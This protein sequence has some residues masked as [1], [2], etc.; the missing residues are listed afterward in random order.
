M[1]ARRRSRSFALALGRVDAAESALV[2]NPHTDGQHQRDP[3]AQQRALLG[4][5]AYSCP[6]GSPA[7]P[8]ISDSPQKRVNADWKRFRPMNTVMRSHHGDTQ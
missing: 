4:G 7:F 8:R 1:R 2:E 6:F 5:R 3:D